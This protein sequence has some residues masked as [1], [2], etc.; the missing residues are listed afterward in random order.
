MVRTSSPAPVQSAPDSPNT[1]RTGMMP[2]PSARKGDEP[3][4]Q[5]PRPLRQKFVSRLTSLTTSEL[6]AI[7]PNCGAKSKHFDLW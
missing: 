1:R 6:V 3:N 4:S 2:R 7:A 5:N